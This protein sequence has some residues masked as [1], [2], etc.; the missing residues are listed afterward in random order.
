MAWHDSIVLDARRV[1]DWARKL[2][3]IGVIMVSVQL[4]FRGTAGKQFRF[5]VKDLPAAR[6]SPNV[7][8]GK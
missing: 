1:R 5:A 4:L 7:I 8:H 6:C 3:E 2:G